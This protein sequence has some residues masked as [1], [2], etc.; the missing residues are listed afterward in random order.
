MLKILNLNVKKIGLNTVNV[1]K[2][3]STP[4]KKVEEFASSRG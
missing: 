4:L 3:G 1:K 2:I